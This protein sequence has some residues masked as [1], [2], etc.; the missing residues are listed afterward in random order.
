MTPNRITPKREAYIRANPEFAENQD[1]RDLLLELD[2]VC[3]ERDHLR[4]KLSCEGCDRFDS[5]SDLPA[6]I[7]CP[8][9]AS[10]WTEQAVAA[11]RDRILLEV[12]KVRQSVFAKPNTGPNVEVT[13]CAA[14]DAVR[15]LIQRA[16]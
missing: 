16:T 4:G 7:L 2:A 12:S 11:E 13:W 14:C 6:W 15:D 3:A 10:R 1:A 8:D 9:C 5:G